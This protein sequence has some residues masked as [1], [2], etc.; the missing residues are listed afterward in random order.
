M[1]KKFLC[2]ECGATNVYKDIVSDKCNYCGAIIE[3]QG[4]EII[5]SNDVKQAALDATSFQ[6]SLI[7]EI[8]GQKASITDMW[9]SLVSNRAKGQD[10]LIKFCRNLNVRIRFCIEAFQNLSDEAKYEVGDF[11][12]TQ[13]ESI[14]KFRVKH[15]VIYLDELDDINAM[16][17]KQMYDLKG[18]GIFQFKAK[19]VI[20]KRIKR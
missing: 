17:E 15:K 14:M 12:C 1:A 18:R 20:K 9:E 2:T 13:M 5:V 4:S 8:N 19:S 7:V 3:S 6:K 16:I 10:S 11:I